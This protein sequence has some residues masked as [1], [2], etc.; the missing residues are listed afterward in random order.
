ML[1][2]TQPTSVAVVPR[3]QQSSV[4]VRSRAMAKKYTLEFFRE[5]SAAF[6]GTRENVKFAPVSEI[7]HKVGSSDFCNVSV[8][9]Q[10]IEGLLRTSEPDDPR[11]WEAQN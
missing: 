4:S 10:A 5:K 9:F 7:S 3:A 2:H 6:I 1:T 8:G 11:L